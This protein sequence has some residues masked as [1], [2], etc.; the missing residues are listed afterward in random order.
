MPQLLDRI[1]FPKIVIVLAVTFGVAL[2]ACGLTAI[3]LTAI[4]GTL[5]GNFAITLGLIELGVMLLSLLGLVLTLIAWAIAA[6][7]RTRGG[8]G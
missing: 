5:G 7:T 4:G 8:T 3:G 2:G 1:N 6:A